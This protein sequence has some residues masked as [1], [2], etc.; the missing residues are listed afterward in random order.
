MTT[1]PQR[2]KCDVDD[3]VCQLQ[4]LS[5][6]RGMQSAFGDEEFKSKF[7]E[8][9]GWDKKIVDTIARQEVDLNET[10]KSCGLSSAEELK[11]VTLQPMEP[12]KEAPEE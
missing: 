6:L 7:P 1:E 2:P 12:A 3:I 8:F 4:V 5:H 9:D 11:D 10:L